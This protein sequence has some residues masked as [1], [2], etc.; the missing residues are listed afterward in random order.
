MSYKD[1]VDGLK[2]LGFEPEE[3]GGG[4]IV[5]AYR[6]PAGRLMGTEIKLGLTVGEDFPFNPPT[7]PRVSPRLFPIHPGSDVP[8]PDGGVHEASE[9]GPDWEYWSRPCAGWQTSDRSV[10]AYMRHI[11]DL[12]AKIP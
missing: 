5:F 12:F 11:R 9:Y 7:G 6:I 2:T 4:R 1:F 10:A 8:H 3:P